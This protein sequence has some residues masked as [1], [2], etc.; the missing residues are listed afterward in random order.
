[1]DKNGASIAAIDQTIED[2]K[3]IENVLNDKLEQCRH[4]IEDLHT[5]RNRLTKTQALEGE[6]LVE[7]LDESYINENKTLLGLK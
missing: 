3:E 4:S 6:M 5:L 2:L 7:G 1:M